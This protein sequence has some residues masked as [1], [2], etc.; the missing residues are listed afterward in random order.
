[1]RAA[2]CFLPVLLAGCAALGEQKPSSLPGD[3]HARPDARELAEHPCRYGDSALCIAKCEH[4]D[5]QA[6]N[7]AGV[8]FEF[9]E[10][11]DVA[12]ASSYYRRSC[13]GSYGP[14]CDNLGWL[15]LRGRGVPRDQ[16]QAMVLFLAAFDAARLACLRGDGSGCLL[17]GEILYDGRGVKEDDDQAVAYF[18]RACDDGEPKG[19]DLASRGE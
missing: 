14:G 11:Q 4:D 18:H 12:S 3:V 7:G 17:A 9:G 8:L 1:M 5:P 15:Y 2:W 10:S 16:P 19:C 6:C 13:D